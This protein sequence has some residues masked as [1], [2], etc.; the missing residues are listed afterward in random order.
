MWDADPTV[1]SYEPLTDEH[2]DR[3]A[4]LADEDHQAFNRLDGRPEDRPRRLLIV[5]AQS[6][7]R[8]YVDC[9]AGADRDHRAGVKDLD[10]WT[11]YAAI[12]GLQFPAAERETHADVG[13]SVLG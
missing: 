11:F 4:N 6:A 8:H 2:L 3:L 1:P 7:A 5:L 9:R 12:P 13:T 10:V